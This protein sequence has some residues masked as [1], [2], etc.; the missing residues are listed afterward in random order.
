MNALF[1]ILNDLQSHAHGPFA[2]ER[3]CFS[4]TEGAALPLDLLLGE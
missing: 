1:S 2:S 3:Q 4:L